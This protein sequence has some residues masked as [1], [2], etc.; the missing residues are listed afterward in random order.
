M[1]TKVRIDNTRIER[2]MIL[3]S[4]GIGNL[5]MFS[6]ALD[7]IRKQFSDADITMIILKPG[8]RQ[9]YE[10]DPRIDDIY[11]I[12]AGKDTGKKRQLE[13]LNEVRRKKFDLTV[14][15]FPSNRKEY[16]LIPFWSGAR[17]R[18][19]NRYDSKFFKSLSFLQN[20]RVPMR[21]D[22]HDLDQNL[23]MALILGANPDSADKQMKFYTSEQ[24]RLDADNF[25]KNNN[26]NGKRE[27]FG[28]HPGSS[29]ERGMD[30]KQWEVEKFGRLGDRLADNFNARM[31]IFGGP[32]EEELKDRVK[33]NTGHD[34]VVVNGI[35]LRASAELIGKCRF[36]VSNDSGLM[37]IAVAKNVR[38]FAMFGPSD[39][40][41]T[42]PY[43]EKHTVIRKGLECSPC[44]NI[45]NVGLGYVP[46]IYKSNI[47]IQQITV[48]DV[49]SAITEKIKT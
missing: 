4:I 27:L 29:V 49:Y 20:F 35:S 25:L 39:P 16:N 36:F 13:I 22:L 38:T 33:S 28:I 37:H 34:A 8:F 24:D 3:G 21:H 26:I 18:I 15:T 2:I 11:L 41:R 14:T 17:Y 46:C 40:L 31:L 43:G 7:C 9:L 19:S 45:N 1:I 12:D 30:F 5:L 10:C 6:P 42:A 23:N 44:W 48:E 32:D 47:C